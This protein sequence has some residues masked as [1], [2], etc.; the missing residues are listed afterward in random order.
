MRLVTRDVIAH[1]VRSHSPPK[2]CAAQACFCT[3]G[4]GGDSGLC[5]CRHRVQHEHVVAQG[6]Q[7][8]P[9]GGPGA[10]DALTAAP[11]AELTDRAARRGA[12]GSHHRAARHLRRRPRRRV[13]PS[14][15]GLW[16]IAPTS[17]PRLRSAG[18]AHCGRRSHARWC[19]R[20]WVSQCLG[21]SGDTCA[22]AYL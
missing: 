6:A 12:R 10:G 8:P 15:P 14:P 11:A 21:S 4:S 1:G 5:C 16:S 9:G 20:R 7:Q 13:A 19:R 18:P 17:R 3:G 2:P 22:G